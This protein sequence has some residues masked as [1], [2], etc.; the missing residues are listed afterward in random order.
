MEGRRDMARWKPAEL[1]SRRKEKA[2]ALWA[3]LKRNAVLL[4]YV[5]ILAALLGVMEWRVRRAGLHPTKI[6]RGSLL[7]VALQWFA[8][9]E[10]LRY[11]ATADLKHNHKIQPEDVTPS[12]A[13]LSNYLPVVDTFVGKYLKQDVRAGEA[14][15]PK[16]LAD[17]P[18]L[19]PDSDKWMITVRVTAEPRSEKAL[20]PDSAISLVLPSHDKLEGKIV[21]TSRD[22]PMSKKTS[23]TEKKQ[24]KDA[25]EK[26]SPSPSPPPEQHNE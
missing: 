20:E 24:T 17:A 26:P 16:N 4:L 5:L 12:D 10:R 2:S 18:I 1:W 19:K 9:P 15:L 21:T 25:A 6:D 14:V 7:V 11:V 3:A 8:H 13:S 23:V 22:I